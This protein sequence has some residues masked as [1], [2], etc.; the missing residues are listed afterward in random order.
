MET[1]LHR[2][3]SQW[4][5]PRIERT[6]KHALIN[7]IVI[8]LCAVL[9]GAE[10][11]VGIERFGKTKQK[12]LTTLLDLSEGIPSHDTFS[13]VFSIL[14]ME[15]F[16]QCF[17]AWVESLASQL[18][19]IIAI[20]GKSMRGTR[21]ET[22]GP[23]HLVNAWCV[24]NQL[25]LG[26]LKVAEKS[27]EITAILLLLELLSI[28][29]ATIT[30][31][32]IHC[33]KELT[34]LIR[35]KQ[36]DY[37]LALKG[38][39]SILY[40]DVALYMRSVETKTKDNSFYHYQTVEKDQGRLETREYWAVDN[41]SWLTKTGWKDLQSIVMVKSI[42]EIKG[43]QSEEYRFFITSLAASSIDLIAKAIRG[44]W[45]VE[46]N[47]HWQLDVSFSEDR[48]CSKQG[49]AAANR[50]LLN[51]MALNLLKSEKTIKVGIK[52]KRLMAGWDDAYLLKVLTAGVI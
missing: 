27:N 29:G 10:D 34:H 33:Q 40:E 4:P 26:Q 3:F 38:N 36:A 49:H 43:Q 19:G 14:N 7:I 41:L 39:Q 23:L 31:D 20:D 11:W 2:Y 17:I 21:S 24:E 44:H 50:A 32:A 47:V 42:R 30:A 25:V 6:K 13:R 35:D 18:K 15:I 37:V 8:A 46:N 48:W 52:N 9:C 45:Q 22:K 16:G 12:W 28:E 5:D 1:S 51:K